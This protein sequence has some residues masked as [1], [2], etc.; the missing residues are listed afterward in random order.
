MAKYIIAAYSGNYGHYVVKKEP[1]G[2]FSSAS[3]YIYKNGEYWKS[4]SSP[5]SAYEII[6]DYDP[7]I[8][9]EDIN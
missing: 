7:H 3:Y 6:K 9:T 5:S 8:K 1:G 4:A 2:V